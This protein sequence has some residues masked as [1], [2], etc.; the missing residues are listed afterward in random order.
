L[1]FRTDNGP[2][3]LYIANKRFLTS[4]EVQARLISTARKEGLF[5][6]GKFL[7]Y[8]LKIEQV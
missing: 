8:P 6:E 7:D 3:F 1:E 2:H 4:V 5:I